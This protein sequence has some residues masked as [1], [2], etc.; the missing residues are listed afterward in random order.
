MGSYA[1][2]KESYDVF[3][4]LFEPMILSYFKTK[5]YHCGKDFGDLSKKENRD[6]SCG[7]LPSIF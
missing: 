1:C 5:K 7:E 2:D 6:V 3:E 4:D